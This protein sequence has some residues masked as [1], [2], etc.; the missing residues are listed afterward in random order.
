MNHYAAGVFSRF[1]LFL[2]IPLCWQYLAAETTVP[3]SGALGPQQTAENPTNAITG[4]VTLPAI[5][6]PIPTYTFETNAAGEITTIT[7]RLFAAPDRTHKKITPEIVITAEGAV[8]N[9]PELAHSIEVDGNLNRSDSVVMHLPATGAGRVALQGHAIGVGLIDA[10]GNQVWLGQIKDCAGEID[11]DNRNVIRWR[12]AFEGIRGDVVLIYG[13]TYF[14]QLVVL[15]E[16][17]VV[18]DDIDPNTARLFVAS[19]FFTPPEPRKE[20]RKIKLREDLYLERNHGVLEIEDEI[21]DWG[22]MRMADGRAFVWQKSSGAAVKPSVPT[23]K[24]WVKNG[25]IRRVCS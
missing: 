22:W 18:P 3:D 17:P 25:F 2:C 13:Q 16:N 4:E 15:K 1:A 23:S 12:D 11:K 7:N 24:A 19:E 14:E 21:L 8:G 5:K 20:N 6:E 10:T 9:H